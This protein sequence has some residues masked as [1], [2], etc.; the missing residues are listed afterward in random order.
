M[1]RKYE[2]LLAI[3]VLIVGVVNIILVGF[4]SHQF[5]LGIFCIL[6]AGYWF[7]SSRKRRKNDK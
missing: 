3:L 6:L 4:I 7:Y 5:P 2:L 1:K